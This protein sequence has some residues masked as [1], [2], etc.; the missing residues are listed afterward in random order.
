MR[1]RIDRGRVSPS[2]TSGDREVRSLGTE[3]GRRAGAGRHAVGRLAVSACCLGAAWGWLAAD[4]S[5][6]ARA[7]APPPAAEAA[8]PRPG[9]EDALAAG[10]YTAAQA[11]RG[12]TVYQEHCRSC[13]GSS[14]RGGA[15]EFAAPALAGPFFFD[16]WSGRPVAELLAYSAESM[17]PEGSLLPEPDYVDIT[18]YILQVL[19][20]PEGDTELTA[21]SPA[22]AGGIERQRQP[23]R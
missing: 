15:N 2:P 9:Q 8:E 17:P 21:D 7:A 13:H 11:E 14:L 6:A 10:A 19:G 23:P 22:L 20:Y 5:P 16:A 3:P 4:T 1:W 18:A 12:R